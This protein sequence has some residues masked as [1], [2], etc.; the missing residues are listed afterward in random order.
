[1]HSSE[2]LH[3]PPEL[4]CEPDGDVHFT[5][6]RISLIHFIKYWREDRTIEKVLVTLPTLNRE[7]VEAA[8]SYIAAYPVEVGEYVKWEEEGMAANYEAWL[9]SDRKG[10]S[11]AEM[12]ERM[13]LL[14][15]RMA[16]EQQ[17]Q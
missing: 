11:F 1:M 13:R 5:G 2:T 16:Q 12:K 4:T 17:L 7:K 3:L 14:R 15:E 8:L 9:K 6:H 10:P